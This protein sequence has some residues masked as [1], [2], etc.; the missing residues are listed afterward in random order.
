MKRFLRNYIGPLFFTTRVFIIVTVIVIGF[1]V[2]FFYP[3]ISIFPRLAFMALMLLLALD[4]FLVFGRKEGL[5][6][7]RITPER[8]SNGDENMLFVY[9]ENR[10]PFPVSVGVIDEIPFQF[11]KRDVWFRLTLNP[12]QEKKIEYNLRPVK[13]GG[14][15]FGHVNAF[16]STPLGLLMRRYR[17]DENAEVPV[18]PS[19]LQM[20]KY[21]LL[22]VSNRLS[23]IGIKKIRKIGHSMEFEQ[24]KEYV[25]GDDY[26]TVNWRATARRGQLM[27]NHYTDEKSQ[28]IYCIINKGRMMKMPFEGL[29]LLDYAVNTSLV[30]SNVA[31]LKQD[32]AG[33]I[34]FSEEIGAFL[35][36]DRRAVQMNA[37]LEVLYNQKTRYLESDFEKLYTLIRNKITQRSLLVLFTNFESMSS[38]QRELPYLRKIAS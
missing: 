31:L 33:L 3:W 34:T 13:R 29:S 36:A 9:I 2:A 11:Q 23:E 24:I 19:Y 1:L 7:R 18:Y 27:V 17:F 38:L 37:I 25:P 30:L 5:F 35:P 10:Y 26:R 14:Y 22:A 32:K 6:A 21:Q 12:R 15:S 20:R 28:Q 4:Y 8:L 16:V